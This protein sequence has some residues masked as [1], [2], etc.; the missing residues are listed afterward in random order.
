MNQK[1]VTPT[2]DIV[3]TIYDKLE[4][5]SQLPDHAEVFNKALSEIADVIGF[6]K[7]DELSDAAMQMLNA[8]K[9]AAFKA[10]W[11]CRG[12]I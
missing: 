2:I 12:A 4:S 11:A 6:E 9:E 1:S 10:G 3:Q 5:T 7:Q 8:A